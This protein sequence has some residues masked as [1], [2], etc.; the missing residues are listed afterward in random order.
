MAESDPSDTLRAAPSRQPAGG[1][2]DGVDELLASVL[3]REGP[4]VTR[5]RE[6]DSGG[7]GRIEVV[8]D[9]LLQREMARKVLHDELG[10]DTRA[11]R[12]FLREAQITAQ[13]DHPSIVPVHDLS[14]THGELEFT[15]KM[16]RGRTLTAR[17]RALPEGPLAPED[18][19]ELLGVILRI[20]DALALA[21]AK[22]VLHCDIKPENIMLGDWGE[23]YLMDWGIARP[24]EPRRGPGAPEPIRISVGEEGTGMIAGTP[25]YMAPEQVL[26][27]VLDPRTDVFAMGA[28][29]YELVTRHPPYEASDVI[30]LLQLAERGEVRLPSESFPDAGVPRSLERIIM[31]A[32]ARDPAERYGRV[33]DLRLALQQFLLGGAEFRRLRLRPGQHV[34]REGETGDSAYIVERGRLRVYKR[35][36][37]E[38]RTLRTLGRGDVFG[39]TAILAESPRTASVVA[40]EECWLV[41]V[42]RD[43]LEREID[44]LKAWVGVFVR[45]LAR[46]FKEREEEAACTRPSRARQSSVSS[47]ELANLVLMNLLTWGAREPPGRL[48]M[49]WDR[50]A[51]E[52]MQLTGADA[53]ELWDALQGHPELVI[54]LVGD[55]ITCTDPGA[56][57]RRLR[58]ERR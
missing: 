47:H 28:V 15:M 31:K 7:M 21:H 4:R 25:A 10:R 38:E 43:T 29:L 49:P 23:V 16:V 33:E 27:E 19:A 40:L 58:A 20:C 51:T 55:R 14:L 32:L 48:V 30:E 50:L 24:C 34:V 35:F 41:V 39:E 12:H 57:R 18:L 54:D 11:V 3:Q 53:T 46:R 9:R 56:V 8:R 5:M 37:D 2:G 22:G 1:T 26:G 52:L 42:S 44:G 45:T 17:I 36:G 6:L 13:L